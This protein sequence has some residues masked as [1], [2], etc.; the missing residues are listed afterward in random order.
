MVWAAVDVRADL[1][2]DVGIG[3]LT[4]NWG[5]EG[6]V[7]LGF[8]ARGSP[9]N[10]VNERQLNFT[11]QLYYLTHACGPSLQVYWKV[12]PHGGRRPVMS[13][14]QWHTEKTI[15]LHTPPELLLDDWDVTWKPDIAA[16]FPKDDKGQLVMNFCTVLQ[17]AKCAL[18]VPQALSFPCHPCHCA[19]PFC[20][21][22]K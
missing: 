8:I 3:A 9:A 13:Y 20:A 21:R 19:R 17:F 7:G 2:R 16:S 10:C 11:L 4:Q 6:W 12:V 14:L 5:I 22:V 18:K 15:A 1:C